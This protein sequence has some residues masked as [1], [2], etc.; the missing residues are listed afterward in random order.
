MPGRAGP[1]NSCRIRRDDTP[2]RLFTSLDSAAVGG[3]LTSRWTW[4]A[5]PLNSAR[6][7]PKSA[8]TSRMISSMRV[9]CAAVNTGCRYFVTKTKCACRMKTQCLPVR[10][11]PYSAM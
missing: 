9:R 6:P 11:S 7:V 1:G 8:H 3:K 10:T 5:S 2:L 4:F